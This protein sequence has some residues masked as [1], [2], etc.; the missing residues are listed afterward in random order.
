MRYKDVGP[1]KQYQEY[2]EGPEW[3]EIKNFYYENCGEYKCAICPNHWRLV[4]HKRS[5]QFLTMK[6]LRR[7]FVFK[8]LIVAY[9][10]RNMVWLCFPHNGQVHFKK[11]KRVP[12]DYKSLMKR[13]DEVRLQY[14]LQKIRQLRPSDILGAIGR[15]LSQM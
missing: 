12:L 11:G 4:L 8:F 7:R 10:K 3:Q 5:Y 13:E 6:A 14:H 2:V 1:Y 9:L 15:T